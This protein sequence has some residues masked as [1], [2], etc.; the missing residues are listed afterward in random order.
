MRESTCL[1]PLLSIFSSPFISALF[2]VIVAFTFSKSM[3]VVQTDLEDELLEEEVFL[4][5]YL[6]YHFYFVEFF[7]LPDLYLMVMDSRLF[8]K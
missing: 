7:I 2:F 8:F 3:T 4:R 5:S 6:H 1:F